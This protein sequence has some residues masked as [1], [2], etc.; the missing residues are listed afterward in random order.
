MLATFDPFAATPSCW[1]ELA[2]NSQHSASFVVVS[3]P[4]V[5]MPSCC[6][7]FTSEPSITARKLT[8]TSIIIA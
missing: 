1:L 3:L 5:A 7:A 8:N 2:T 4:I 6:I